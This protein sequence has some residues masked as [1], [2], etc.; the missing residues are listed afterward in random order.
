MNDCILC[1][2]PLVTDGEETVILQQK[3][4]DSILAASEARGSAITVNLNQVVHVRCRLDFTNKKA[5]QSYLKRKHSSQPE[6]AQHHTLRSEESTFSYADDCILCGCPDAYQ[7]KK[8]DHKLI[9]VRT[10]GFQD[11]I[12]KACDEFRGEWADT[13][14]GRV[15]F[16][17]D[18]PAADA[19][20]HNMCSINFR[21]GKQTPKIFQKST[22]QRA[23][24]CKKIGGSGRPK[25]SQ[26]YEAFQAVTE[27]L[28]I[29]DDE[30]VTIS[31]LIDKMKEFLTNTD[32]EP[33][34]FPHM[35]SELK[36][37]FQDRIVIT[38]INGKQ[39]VVTLTT[40]ASK[41]LH[42]FHQ[43]TQ[44]KEGDE[45]NQI[46]EAAAKLIK[47][48]IREMS[49]T[50]DTYP[51]TEDL[52][53]ETAKQFLP[54][55]LLL[56]LMTL[57]CGKDSRSKIPSI[58]Q[59][60]MQATRPRILLAP[61]LIGLGV[62]MHH[63]FQSKFLVDSLH[64]HGFSCSYSEV[65]M[66]ER[67]ASV[68]QGTQIPNLTP[69]TFVQYSGDNV[70]H[71]VRS[72]D[73]KGTFHGMGIIAMVTPGTKSGRRIP[74]VQVT[75]E[76]IASVGQIQIHQFLSE[77]DSLQSLCYQTITNP[78]VKEP[79]ADVDLLWKSSL[80]LKVPRPQWSGFM[81][82]IHKGEHPG[83]SSVTFLPMIDMDPNDL[84]CIYSTL[85]FISSHA[86]RHQ[87]YPVVTFDQPLW[88][89]AHTMV[90]SVPELQPAV[91][92]LGGF[93]TQMS[94]LGSIGHLMDGSGL[95]ELLEVV[96]ASNTVGHMLSG[97]AVSRAV[98]GH[99]LVD[100]ALN[101]MVTSSAL[102]IDL[103]QSSVPAQPDESANPDDDST[104]E[105]PPPSIA[106]ASDSTEAAFEDTL[107]S[108]L[109]KLLEGILS[110]STSSSD[111]ENSDAMNTLRENVE[112]EKKRLGEYRI[113][114]L[115]LQYM[116]LVDLLRRFIKAE[117]LGIWA[118]HLQCLHDML[119]YLA[120]SG[121]NL[122]VK[123]V[124]VY[125]QNMLK[126]ETDLPEIHTH[127]M[128]GLHV[129]RRSDRLWAGLSTD[130]AIEQCLMR[131][132]KTR[133]GLTRGRG[134]TETQRLIWV[135]STPACAEINSAMQDFTGTTFT[136]S[137]QHKETTSARMTKDSNDVQNLLQYL[138]QRNP[139]STDGPKSLRSIATGVTA[140]ASVNCDT[141][142][143][144]GQQIMQSMKD[145]KVVE[146]TF[147]KKDQV[148]T[149]GTK[150][151]VK[152]RDEVVSVDPLLLFQRLS[153][154][155]AR[156]GD[157]QDVFTYELCSYPPA[158]FESPDVM[159][160]GNKA[161]L[162]DS[163]WC[164]AVADSLKPPDQVQYVLDGGA[165][166]HRIPWVKGALWDAILR[167]YT[168]YVT[169]RY[170]KA[171][172]VF[173]GY[174]DSPSTKDCTHT[175][176]SG[177]CIG[178]AVHFDDTMVLQTKKEV[179][180]SNTENKQRFI[181]MLGNRL[182]T[183]GCCVHHA[184]GDADLLI[185]EVAVACAAHI[186]TVVIAD[187]TDILVLLI[188]HAGRAKYNVWFKPNIK[189][190]SKKAQRCWNMT[191]T[192]CHLGSTVC[193]C[194]LFI[195]AVL[196][197][198]TTSRLYGIG[199]YKAV[200]K[201]KSDIFFARQAEVF[202][203]SNAST[204]DVIEAGNN[205]LVSLYNGEKDENLDHLRLRRFY[206]KTACSTAAV[207]PRTLPPTSAAAKYH[208]LRVYQQ[209]Q[210]WLGNDG[211]DVP[212]DQWGWKVSDGRMVPILTDN[213]PAPQELLQVIR[214]T[215]RTGCYTMRCTCRKNGLDCSM[216]C[217]ECRGVCSNT[218]LLAGDSDS[219][220]E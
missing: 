125:L 177:G 5:I 131:A 168:E 211:Q 191:A 148:V 203:D 54:P 12:L 77:R 108:A 82:L 151:S 208:S 15:T 3:G 24:K 62:Q 189:R 183:A 91:I 143:H 187:D 124:H 60:I 205:V 120:A 136:T 44:Q 164:P 26:T 25:N 132:L 81:Q 193:S 175:L 194:I 20:Y 27:Y 95:Q 180:L 144:V 171:I 109:A 6:Q 103:P 99:L 36:R 49:Q 102:K 39:N 83:T 156:C 145:Q 162:A 57:F 206:E 59:A 186:H 163:L 207:E 66:F 94:F 9:R 14:R 76:D 123:S 215:C 216:A 159:R 34:S 167:M 90:Q 129:V 31:D 73:G 154:A 61:L 16:V 29:N 176:R 160:S 18:L 106:D 68:A 153:T 170:G 58:G 197:C 56:L 209:V 64:Q 93:H 105:E 46:I 69:N 157:L 4:C 116:D 137:E 1:Q 142:Q 55:S 113:A 33:Y 179:F 188:H 135:L 17:Q 133:G 181:T 119:P 85:K 182:E 158:L 41:I 134:I 198:D 138:T 201:V 2:K 22:E 38:E 84:S 112:A 195:H 126:L 37:H 190:E 48:D 114:K 92:R 7:G 45:K 121:H 149:M 107:L 139:F 122:Y 115:W 212:A 218:S 11:K 185:V 141:A 98:R 30:Q 40:T 217:S 146:Y 13:V 204:D 78:N 202:M 10:L 50:R 199:K 65:K 169:H 192:R 165:L 32:I 51:S 80:L 111:L 67:S 118:L 86:R 104:A 155:G 70:D 43:Q 96:Y 110:E 71:N 220:D 53:T 172:I 196:G 19:V 101:A 52:S 166:L 72:L 213:P 35:K 152:I 117:R 100:A 23:S 200:V 184:N 8:T 75:S 21:T 174:L 63:H 128:N 130:L 161:S 88:W 47:Q 173:D 210:V 28:E 140:H 79:H 89:K 42:N 150:G 214:C 87:S 74:R 178:A 219:E 147:R 97:K 127:F